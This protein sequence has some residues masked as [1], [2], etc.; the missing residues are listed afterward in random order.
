MAYY[1]RIAEQWHAASGEQGGAFKALVLNDVLLAK[2]PDIQGR[3]ILEVGAGNGYFLPLLL[4]GRAGQAPARVVVSDQSARLLA[5]ARRH[6]R[7]PSAEYQVMDAAEPFPFGDGR[8]DLLLATMIFN[9]LAAPAFRNA[10]ADCR[11]VLA[12][13]GLFLMSVLHPDFVSSLL[14]GG[15]IQRAGG[16]LTMPGA[17]SLRLPVVLR[18]DET[19]RSALSAAGFQ[20]ESETVFAT[21]A[22]RQATPGLRRAAGAPLA[23]VFSCTGAV[24]GQPDAQAPQ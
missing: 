18:T 5:I 1:D 17:G 3:S 20:F 24:R 14:H 22:V 9:D 19:Y 10:L 11:R 7:V 6:F 23:L 15:A 12:R 16:A 8:F 21:E 13:G 4:R 2:L